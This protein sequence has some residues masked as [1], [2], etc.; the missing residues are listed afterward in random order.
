VF[1]AQP[2][3]GEAWYLVS[4]EILDVQ[5]AGRV[6]LV[7]TRLAAQR[8]VEG[9]HEVASHDQI[10]RYLAEQETHKLYIVEAQRRLSGRISVTVRATEPK[11]RTE[12]R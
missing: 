6:V 9:T 5:Q 3:D 12:A 1:H 4:R 8:I 11:P 2:S 7:G 10:K